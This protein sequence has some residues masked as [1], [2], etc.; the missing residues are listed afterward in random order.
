MESAD[1]P[2]GRAAAGV[3]MGSLQYTEDPGAALGRFRSWGAPG[4][5]VAV[6]VDGLV[7]LLVEL[8]RSGREDEAEERRRTRRG[9]WTS[10]GSSA[11]LHLFDAASLAD[12]MRGAGLI[13]VEVRGLLCGWTLLGPDRLVQDLRER[14]DESYRRECEWAAD[15][16]LT[17]LGKQ[18]LGLA[19]VPD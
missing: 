8:A 13:D 19:R 16:S 6:L 15:P 7:A 1:L 4:A 9:V 11:D 3:A 10:E 18:L 12:A 17:D 5:T 2:E 14:P